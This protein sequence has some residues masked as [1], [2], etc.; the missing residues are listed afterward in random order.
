MSKPTPFKIAVSDDLLSFIHQRV[1]TARIPPGLSLPASEAWSDGIPPAVVEQIREYWEKKYDWRAVEARI[2]GH[3]KMFTLPISEGGEDLTIHFVHHRSSREDAIPLLFQHGWPGSFLEVSKIIDLLTEPKDHEQQAYHVVAP[4]LPG[5][6]FSSCPRGNEFS[7][8]NMA[9]VDQKLMLALGYTKYMAQGGDWGSIVARHIGLMYPESCLAIHVN[10]LFAGM[11]SFWKNPLTFTY[12]MFWAARQD[13]SNKDA[14]GL[15]RIKWWTSEESGY[16][17]IQGTKPQTLS[18][19][20]IDSP[21]AMAAWL[22]DKMECL[23]DDG[24][25]W[26]EEDTIT[27]AM[28]YLIPGHSGHA[29]IYK[30]TKGKKME[31]QKET[32]STPISSKVDFGASVFP[33]DVMIIPRWWAEV[34]VA[35]NFVYWQEH[36]KGGHFASWENPDVLV[37]D[38][39]EFTKKIRPSYRKELME[40]GKSK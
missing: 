16:L 24:F 19:G 3:L 20:L 12:F 31:A 8:K 35:S 17:E 29:Q 37:Q 11:P 13:T 10:L 30:N 6:T 23:I 32:L 18:Y 38:I 34:D 21:I 22:R 5:F 36:E 9:A 26:S 2:N 1:S 15:G 14:S 27:W 40:I 33:K 28:M 4:S 39:R 7:I 25:E